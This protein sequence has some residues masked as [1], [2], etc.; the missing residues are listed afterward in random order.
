[1]KV[2]Q[3]MKNDFFFAI[4]FALLSILSISFV[5]FSVLTLQDVFFDT[6]NYLKL[7]LTPNLLVIISGLSLNF[8]L[9]HWLAI[10]IEKEEKNVINDLSNSNIY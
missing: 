1:M 4:L 9:F 10:Q 5:Y 2:I 6:Q 3:L 7:L 8:I